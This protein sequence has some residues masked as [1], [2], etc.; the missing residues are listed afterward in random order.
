MMRSLA[1]VV[2]TVLAVTTFDA[3][4]GAARRSPISPAPTAAKA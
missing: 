1:C 2:L 4:L 3:V